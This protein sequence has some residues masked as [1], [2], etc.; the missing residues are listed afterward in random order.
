MKIIVE[1]AE[2]KVEIGN[3]LIA[4]KQGSIMRKIIFT[5]L[6][7]NKYFIYVYGM[8]KSMDSTVINIKIKLK[9][10]KN[11]R[12]QAHFPSMHLHRDALA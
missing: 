5:V 2:L 11:R 3:F 6:K 7:I 1:I 4:M 10:K 9:G 8:I 12:L